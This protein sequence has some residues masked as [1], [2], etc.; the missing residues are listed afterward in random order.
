[1]SVRHA[2]MV[3]E[4]VENPNEK[5][6]VTYMIMV[7]DEPLEV[8]PESIEKMKGLDECLTEPIKFAESVREIVKKDDEKAEEKKRACSTGLLFP[9]TQKAT[10][11]LGA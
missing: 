7:I 2:G 5:V 4:I 6:E 1:M 3:K 9:K 8:F 11:Y 10:G